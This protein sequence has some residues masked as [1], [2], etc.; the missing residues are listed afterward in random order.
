MFRRTG[1]GRLQEF[2]ETAL[3]HIQSEDLRRLVEP[4][5]VK[6]DHAEA[7][8][9]VEMTNKLPAADL[10]YMKEKGAIGAAVFAAAMLHHFG[11]IGARGDLVFEYEL[12]GGRDV[13]ALYPERRFDILFLKPTTAARTGNV[14]FNIEAKNYKSANMSTLTSLNKQI[15]YDE[16]RL[17]PKGGLQPIVPVWTFMQGLSDEGVRRA[18]EVRNFRVLD[19]AQPNLKLEMNHAFRVSDSLRG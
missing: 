12:W 10:D 5:F 17:N 8:R 7:R 1:L 2:R 19:F 11:S 15:L 16:K 9:A 18:L 3:H 6:F 13:G 14:T 4:L